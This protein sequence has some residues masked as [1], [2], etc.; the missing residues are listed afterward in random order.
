MLLGG[1]GLLLASMVG[2]ASAQTI[3]RTSPPTMVR[4][5]PPVAA[6]STTPPGKVLSAPPK[7]KDGGKTVPPISAPP[8]T[9]PIPAPPLSAGAAT[10]AAVDPAGGAVGE[11]GSDALASAAPQMIGDLGAGGFYSKNATGSAVGRFAT[12]AFKIAENESPRPTD[13]IFSTFNYFNGVNGFGAPRYDVYRTVIGFEKTFLDGDASF[14]MRLPVLAQADGPGAI[15]FDGVGD[16]TLIGKYAFYNDTTT[17]DLLSGGLAVTVPTGVTARLADGSK[18]NSVL[19]QPWAGFILGLDD[20]FAQGFTSIIVPTDSKDIT[21]YTADVG[22]GYRLYQTNEDRF[23][24][25]LIPTVEGHLNVPLK[26]NDRSSLVYFPTTVFVTAGLHAG[27]MNSAWFTLGAA[28][29]VTGP[30]LWDVEFIAQFNLR[31]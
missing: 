5:T 16:L 19:L 27:L 2:M 4:Q 20:A 6:P 17:G 25:A 30:Q 22:I 7:D 8:G 14:G 21:L 13:R 9:A 12:G 23:L 31:F 29:P 3:W 28:I 10:T 1:A 11:R 26:D 15:G 18:L 24:T